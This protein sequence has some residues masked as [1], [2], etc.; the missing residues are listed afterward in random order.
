MV[1]VMYRQKKSKKKWEVGRK[2]FFQKKWEDRRIFKKIMEEKE[3]VR[4]VITQVKK[5]SKK[6]TRCTN[7]GELLGLDPRSC[8]VVCPE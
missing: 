8:W 5:K 6:N 7:T 4:Y 1:S 3:R 2:V